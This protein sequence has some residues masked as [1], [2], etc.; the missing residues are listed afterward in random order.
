MQNLW[1]TLMEY[2]QF[3]LVGALSTL[4][5]I[6]LALLVSYSLGMIIYF[7]Y[8]WNFNGV[9][10]NQGFSVSLAA[11]TILTTMITLAISGNIALSL[12]MVGALSIV[13]YRAAIKD[14]MDILF[15]FW[16]VGSG[17][18]VG[19][20]LH[21]LAFVGALIVILMFLTLN[22][23][24][25]SSDM[26]ILIVHYSGD[27]ID[28][29]LRR[30]LHGKRYQIKSK[31]VRRDDVEMAV[32]LVVKNNNTAFMNTLKDMD[33][34]KDVALIQYTGEYHS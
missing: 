2:L 24:S 33:M 29:E 14:P 11:M 1:S 25:T 3:D 27:A 6:V 5:P 10:F 16:A 13:R 8:K 18:A 31:T 9:V 34:V 32:E 17:I 22:R 26:F 30:I 4:T 19:A 23:K 12:G 21:Y 15:L 20:K 7:V 28:D